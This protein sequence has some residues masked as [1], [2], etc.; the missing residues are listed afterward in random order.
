MIKFDFA[1]GILIL[2]CTLIRGR[3][4]RTKVLHMI[5]PPIWISRL[6]IGPLS[7]PP[8]TVAR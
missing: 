6:K 4:S 1:V 2:V 5:I 8:E 3:P 7:P